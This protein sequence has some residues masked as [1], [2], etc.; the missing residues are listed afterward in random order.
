MG[1]AIL[2]VPKTLI[3]EFNYNC[4]RVQLSEEERV[5]VYYGERD[6]LLLKVKTQNLHNEL[7]NGKINTPNYTNWDRE[8]YTELLKRQDS[9]QLLFF[10]SETGSDMIS[11][12][13][14]LSPILYF[15]LTHNEGINK[16][17]KGV[18]TD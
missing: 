8:V 11:R 7:A 12:G 17:C 2:E 16:R 9:N 15:I 4:A 14:F 1:S 5:E 6:F 10:L 13:I 18:S 3:L